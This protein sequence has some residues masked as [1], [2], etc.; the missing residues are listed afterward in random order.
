LSLDLQ[1]LETRG[2]PHVSVSGSAARARSRR[3][4]AART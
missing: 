2:L 4:G 3:R 1:V